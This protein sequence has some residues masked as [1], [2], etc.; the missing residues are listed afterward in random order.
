MPCDPGV[1]RRHR[2]DRMHPA[3]LAIREAMLAVEALPADERLTRAIVL[4][5]QAQEAVAD[6]VDGVDAPTGSLPAP[7]RITDERQR[8]AVYAAIVAALA[9]THPNREAVA[10][11]LEALVRGDSSG[12]GEVERLTAIVDKQRLVWVRDEMPASW[13]LC[14]PHEA[15]WRA[16]LYTAWDRTGYTFSAAG[17]GLHVP[18]SAKR[19]VLLATWA[20]AD[21]FDPDPIPE[22]APR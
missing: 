4:L 7:A 22:E 21:G 16:A 3:E 10:R 14:R 19:L 13:H 12:Q 20:Q 2:I 8:W 15:H 1:P 11:A 17:R 6:F 5:A 18:D 9:T